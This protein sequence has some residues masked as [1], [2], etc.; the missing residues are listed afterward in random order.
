MDNIIE[1]SLFPI[2]YHRCFKIHCLSK[3]LTISGLNIII[4]EFLLWCTAPGLVSLWY[5]CLCSVRTQVPSLQ[6]CIRSNPWLG[7]I[8]CHREA[9]KEKK[10]YYPKFAYEESLR[11][12]RWEITQSH[13][14][15][16][17]GRLS[18]WVHLITLLCTIPH[19]LLRYR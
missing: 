16:T 18:A 2:H 4:L 13:I 15:S 9:K 17:S 5:R 12:Y 10:N 1:F 3:C 19:S 8:M 11:T 7:N 14:N 6:L